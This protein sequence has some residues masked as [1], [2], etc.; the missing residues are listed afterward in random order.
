MSSEECTSRDSSRFTQSVLKGKPEEAP[1]P[2]KG[3]DVLV[4]R[5]HTEP[6]SRHVMRQG[7][8]R[9]RNSDHGDAAQD[10]AEDTRACMPKVYKMDYGR[11][12]PRRNSAPI[13]ERI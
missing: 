13:R 7:A 5:W 8:A 10:R 11:R 9:S 2:A 6:M 3:N 12:G 4:G 1:I